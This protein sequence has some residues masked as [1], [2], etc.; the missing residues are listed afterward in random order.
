MSALASFRCVRL[1]CSNLIPAAGLITRRLAAM[2]LP[3][4]MKLRGPVKQLSTVADV[5]LASIRADG[6]SVSESTR[7]SRGEETKT[8]TCTAEHAESGEM[9][10]VRA[11]DREQAVCGLAKAL[12]WDLEDG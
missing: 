5:T 2:D 7:V 1:H 12:A 11:A 3:V 9:W 8:Y 10:T 6:Y 4:R